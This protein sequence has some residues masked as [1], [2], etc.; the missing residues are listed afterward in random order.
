[1]FEI[2]IGLLS[3][4]V[5]SMGMGGGTILILLLTIF[6]KYEQQTAQG[7][8]L[9]FFIPTSIISIIIYIKE[10]K[11]KLKLACIISFFGIIGAIVGA[12]IASI[13]QTEQLKKWFAIFLLLIAIHEI[14]S[15]Y[16]QYI[17]KKKKA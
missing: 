10:K 13:I 12:K 2:L 6:F 1:M 17:N 9:L 16:N 3:G 15:F 14:Y 4:I 11:I 5:T 8:N 7:L